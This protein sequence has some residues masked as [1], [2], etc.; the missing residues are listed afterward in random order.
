MDLF[1]RPEDHK[2]ELFQQLNK[3]CR[4]QLCF[5]IRIQAT[6]LRG[7]STIVVRDFSVGHSGIAELCVIE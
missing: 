2:V 7:Y 5:I 4:I 6:E 1:G 3:G